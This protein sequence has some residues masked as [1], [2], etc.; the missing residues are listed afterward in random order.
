M[1]IDETSLLRHLRLKGLSDAGA[2]ALVF[3]VSEDD[4]RRDF[5][6]L[7]AR[8]LAAATSR[9]F[10]LTADGRAA[11]ATAVAAE[12]ATVPDSEM[13]S[14]YEAFCDINGELKAVISA[15]QMRDKLG[16]D[17][18]AIIGRLM[19]LDDRATMLFRMLEQLV[20]RLSH[21]RVGLQRARARIQAGDLDFV[22]RPIIDSYHTVW[23]ELH[24]DLLGLSGRTRAAE[25]E[26]GRAG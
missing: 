1:N 12:R 17:H 21:Y 18:G 4:A 14:G 6:Q 23:F 24:E 9:G 7:I 22:A 8:G 16:D 3:E 11:L 25:A 26:A 19:A 15:W 20:P 2:I 5:E 10:R 13:Q